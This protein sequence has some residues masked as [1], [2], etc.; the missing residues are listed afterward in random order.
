LAAALEPELQ[1][2]LTIL[3]IRF[4]AA[5]GQETAGPVPSGMVLIGFTTKTD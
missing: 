2:A 4:V 3:G 1:A 5:D